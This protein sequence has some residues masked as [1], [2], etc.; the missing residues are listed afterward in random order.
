MIEEV[1]R[2]VRRFKD[3]DSLAGLRAKD[4]IREVIKEME[5]S[6]KKEND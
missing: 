6:C 5:I 2:K 1:I 3:G 4:V